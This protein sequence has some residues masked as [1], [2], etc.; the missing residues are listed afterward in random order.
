MAVRGPSRPPGMRRFSVAAMSLK[1]WREDGVQA[2]APSAGTGRPNPTKSTR[3][4]GV[5]AMSALASLLR[6]LLPQAGQTETT[7][8]QALTR[9]VRGRCPNCGRGKMF[10]GFLKVADRCPE[11]GEELFHQR[12]DDFPAYLVILLVGHIV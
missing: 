3:R 7:A 11:C 12:A 2:T 1:Q 4:R 6:S 10:S 8:A 9:G 5:V